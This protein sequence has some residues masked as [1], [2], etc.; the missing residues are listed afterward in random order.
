[1]SSH[2]YTTS[3]T[4][5]IDSAK[6]NPAESRP[7]LEALCRTYWEPLYAYVRSSGKSHEDAQDITQAF[8][9]HLLEKN[10]PGGADPGLGRFRSYLLGSLRHFMVDYHRHATTQKRGG[11]TLHLVS[12]ENVEDAMVAGDTP[13]AA[14]ERKW[15]HTLIGIALDALA[16]EQNAS[17]HEARFALMRPLLLDPAVDR[18]GIM[19]QLG[20][21]QGM[22]PGHVRTTL[23]RLR[24]RFRE[25]VRQEVS[26]LVA[27][28]SEI[29][30]EIA[31]LLKA[32]M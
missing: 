2:F 13:E 23:S 11:P 31:H 26:R 5:V 9:G 28:A 8:F 17:G 15:A 7:A 30:D 14:Y 25:I 6:T 10:L 4:V 21:Q 12:L 22:T 1:M 27:D 32:M 3:W 19:A 18:E 24:A 16:V 20:T 29:D